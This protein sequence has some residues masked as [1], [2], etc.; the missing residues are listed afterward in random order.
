MVKGKNTLTLTS[1]IRLIA[2]VEWVQP[3]VNKNFKRVCFV[4][5]SKKYIRDKSASM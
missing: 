1:A 5:S 3:L 2:I 4:K